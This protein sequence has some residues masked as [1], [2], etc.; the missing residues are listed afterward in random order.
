MASPRR[1]TSAL[2]FLSRSTVSPFHPGSTPL[3]MSYGDL[4]LRVDANRSGHAEVSAVIAVY[5][6]RSLGPDVARFAREV[7]RAA[8]PHSCAR[9]KAFLFAS[10]Q[11]GGVRGLGRPGSGRGAVEPIGNRASTS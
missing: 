2:V 5:A 7:T 4:L 9:A 10:G 11:A 6:P 1:A 3:G 8:R